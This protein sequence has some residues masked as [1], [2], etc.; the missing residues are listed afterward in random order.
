[1][2]ETLNNNGEQIIVTG[3]VTD[4]TSEEKR[5]K[6]DIQ[7]DFYPCRGSGFTSR[8]ITPYKVKTWRDRFLR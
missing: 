3:K 8:V 2:K 4:T 1:M 6:D 5:D 7:P